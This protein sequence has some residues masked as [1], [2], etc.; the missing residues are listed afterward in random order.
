MNQVVISFA[1]ILLQVT[2]P[3]TANLGKIPMTSVYRNIGQYP[4]ATKVPRVL[5]VRV[6]SAIYFSNS[7]YTKESCS[8]ELDGKPMRLEMVGLNI[9][10]PVPIPSMQ[11]G[12]ILWDA[13]TGSSPVVKLSQ[14]VYTVE[15]Q[16]RGLPHAH[17]CLFM[18][19]DCR[20]RTVDHIDP[21]ISAEIPNKDDDPE[22]YDL[23]SEFMMHALVVLIILDVN[24][25]LITNKFI[26]HTSIDGNG[27]PLYRRRNDGSYVDKG[28]VKL[29]N[30]SVVPYH[31]GI[32]KKYQ[33]H[34]NVEWCNQDASIKYLFKYINKGPDKASIAVVQNKDGDE[35]DEEVDEIK[36]HYDCRYLSACEASWRIFSY[37]VHYRTPAVHRHLHGQQQVVYGVNDD[38][39]NILEKPSVASSMFL[40]WMICNEHDQQARKLSYVEFP[41][42]FVWKLDDRRSEPRKRGFSIGRIHSVFP[43][44]GEPYF[45]RMLLNKVKGPRSFAEIRTVNGNEFPTFR[46]ACFALGLLHDDK[47]YIESIE[48]ASHSGSGYYLRSLFA[49][50][51]T[52]NT[53]SRPEF[54]WRKTWEMLSDEILYTQQIKLK[55]PD[56]SLTEEQ[57]KNLTLYEIEKILLWNNSSLKMFD[58]MP[59][60]II[61]IISSSNNRLIAEELAYDKTAM[62]NEFQQ[63]ASSLTDEQRFVF[64]DIMKAVHDKKGGVFFVYGYGG[65]G[66]TFLW[67]TLSTAIRSLLGL[68]EKIGE[69]EVCNKCVKCYQLLQP[70]DVGFV[71]NPNHCFR[72][73]Y[74]VSIPNNWYQSQVEGG[75]ILYYDLWLRLSLICHI[76]NK[77]DCFVWESVYLGNVLARKDLVFK[78]VHCDP[79]LFPGNPLFDISLIGLIY[80]LFVV[81]AEDKVVIEKFNGS[82]FS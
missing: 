51:L 53:L 43:C 66:K 20:L 56:L 81:I 25:W 29:D 52:S 8:N 73:V 2:R 16:K 13:K 70:V 44:L 9:V 76:R 17:I 64:D 34:I 31:K 6:D 60:P 12:L 15:F 22:L 32:L 5:I 42:K 38:L 1:K 24:A 46:E 75:R 68:V 33:S 27:Y 63:L 55:S 79:P 3:R 58:D 19:P 67:K 36:K 4:E 21:I 39:D 72:C 57:L 14:I 18:H 7:N 45:L 26:E 10:T 74:R 77:V 59:Y 30:R 65:T 50:M 49:S 47:E 35:N 54:V 78:R 48:E 69:L 37:D 41:T 62:K 71:P 61:D 80:L 40:A 28:Q 82:D 11:K 23:V